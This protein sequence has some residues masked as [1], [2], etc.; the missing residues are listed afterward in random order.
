[1]STGSG[2]SSRE[3]GPSTRHGHRSSRRLP[4]SVPILP[5]GVSRQVVGST[6]IS[7]QD[8]LENVGELEGDTSSLRASAVSS[9]RA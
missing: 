4:Y 2:H 5:A 1:M 6:R 9:L 3:M 8:S 7:H